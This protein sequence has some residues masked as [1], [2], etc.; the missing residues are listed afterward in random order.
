VAKLRKMPE[1][2]NAN[3]VIMTVRNS[4]LSA[5]MQ[6][7]VMRAAVLGGFRHLGLGL[8][9]RQL[10]I[11]R[12]TANRVIAMH[13]EAKQYTKGRNATLIAAALSRQKLV[14]WAR[15][16]MRNTIKN[17]MKLPF[18]T[19]PLPALNLLATTKQGP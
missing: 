14:N 17:A 12:L 6:T 7:Y 3:Q 8:C 5:E 11:W 9:L 13:E 2:I 19:A 1:H 10:Y 18:P 15:M 4:R 16:A